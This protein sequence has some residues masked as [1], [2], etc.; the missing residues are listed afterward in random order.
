MENTAMA[1]WEEEQA[2][3]RFSSYREH[4]MTEELEWKASE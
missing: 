2:T 4:L 1:V 3:S